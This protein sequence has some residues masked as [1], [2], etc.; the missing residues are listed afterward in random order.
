[1]VEHQTMRDESQ[2]ID[3]LDMFGPQSAD[4]IFLDSLEPSV[5]KE[6]CEIKATQSTQPPNVLELTGGKVS[7]SAA[8]AQ[9][10][11][12]PFVVRVLRLVSNQLSSVPPEAFQLRAL[13]HLDLSDNQIKCLPKD[14]IQLSHSKFLPTCLNKFLFNE[15]AAV[16]VIKSSAWCVLVSF[17]VDPA[18]PAHVRGAIAPLGNARA[19]FRN[20]LGASQPSVRLPRPLAFS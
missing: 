16:I 9:H 1:M 8:L 6:K 12:G 3:S 20:A 15:T 7:L 2:E 13:T 19:L 14:I 17:Q 5:L 10:S 4:E 18:P 11:A